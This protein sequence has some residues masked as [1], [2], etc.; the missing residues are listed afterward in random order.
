MLTLMH[1]LLPQREPE[2]MGVGAA[3]GQGPCT[4][5]EEEQQ[6]QTPAAD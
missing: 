6:C 1:E 3:P 5:E 2:E 4:E